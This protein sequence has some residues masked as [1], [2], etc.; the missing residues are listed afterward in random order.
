VSIVLNASN[1]GGDLDG[2]S[3]R[4]EIGGAVVARKPE[5]L[6]VS[7]GVEYRLPKR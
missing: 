2:L 1:I 6:D 3:C 4:I 5:S 7:C